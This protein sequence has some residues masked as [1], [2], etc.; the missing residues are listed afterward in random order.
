[1][2]WIHL[3]EGGQHS[4]QRYFV[5]QVLSTGEDVILSQED[6][7]HLLT[8]MRSRIDDKIEIVDAQGKLWLTQ[9]K[10]IHSKKDVSL[11]ILSQIEADQVEMPL[12]VTIACGLSKNDKLEWIVQKATELG[13]AAFQPLA[14]SRDVVKWT[15]NKSVDKQERLQKIA[16][17]AAQQSKRLCQP[18]VLPLRTLNHLIDESQAFDVKLVAFEE[19]AKQGQHAALKQVLKQVNPQEKILCVF[20]SEGGL[21]A[22]EVEK[23]LDNGF[24]ACSLGPR[25]LRA[26][27]APLYMLSNLSYEVEL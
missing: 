6:G 22:K 11:D 17:N 25:I 12:H 5:K 8:V 4:L 10:E 21:E 16:D 2:G 23:L 3:S 9:V 26:E 18:A 27:T 20:G 15:A 1:M 19:T 7:H 14:L 24:I 13:M